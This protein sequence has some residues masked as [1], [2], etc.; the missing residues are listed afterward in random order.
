MYEKFRLQVEAALIQ[1]E[2]AD[3]DVQYPVV[4]D[5]RIDIVS[6]DH[7]LPSEHD[8]FGWQYGYEDLSADFSL[9][10]KKS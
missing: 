9:L 4:I 8:A 3:A 5:V 2:L 1:E 6:R 10:I 7:D